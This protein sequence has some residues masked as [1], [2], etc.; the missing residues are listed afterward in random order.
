[1][2]KLSLIAAALVLASSGASAVDVPSTFNVTVALTTACTAGTTA[3]IDFGTYVAF[4]TTD[5]TGS[6]TTTFKCSK[7][8]TPSFRFDSPTVDVQTGSAAA[9]T[10]TLTA[11]GVIK[12]LRYTLSATVPAV[13]PGTAA[14][15][16][17]LGAGG[18]NST[19]DSYAFTINGTI[20]KDQAG[21]PTGAATQ[22]RTIYV[23][24]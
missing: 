2:K 6:T 21:D 7:G 9:S 11:E 20:P 8:M 10:G 5:A 12:G 18:I 3:N 1:M 17:A 22:T 13:V 15:A 16:G 4:Q 19:G 14:K 23:V 24:Y